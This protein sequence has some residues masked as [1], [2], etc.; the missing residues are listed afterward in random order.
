MDEHE[1]VMLM[2]LGKV[3][4]GACAKAK[5]SSDAATLLNLSLLGN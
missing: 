2:W 5:V 3:P 4:M 1:N